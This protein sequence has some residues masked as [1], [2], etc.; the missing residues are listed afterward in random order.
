MAITELQRQVAEKALARMA[1][2]ATAGAQSPGQQLVVKQV[3]AQ[4]KDLEEVEAPATGVRTFVHLVAGA[5]TILPTGKKLVFGG[6]PGGLGYYVTADRDEI[7]WL[8]DLASANSSQITEEIDNRVVTKPRDPAILQAQL[9]AN[10]NSE[11]MLNPTTASA[12]DNIQAHIAA[13][14]AADKQQ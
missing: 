2:N 12:V 11:R 9:D 8:A 1:Q 14:T 13:G 7:E 10:A 3:Q 5:N 4:Q 6:K